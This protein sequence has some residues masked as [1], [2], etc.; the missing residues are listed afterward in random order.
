VGAL[1]DP[2]PR[3][4]LVAAWGVGR[5]GASSATD[6]LVRRLGDDDPLVAHVAVNSLVRLRAYDACANALDS[7]TPK[8]VPGA[9]RALQAMHE[10]RVVELLTQKLSSQQD[11]AVRAAV[12]RALCRLAYREADWDGG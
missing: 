6:A 3:L 5:L 1:D 12:Y 4:R 11:A 8:L 10:T 2:D 9:A 7:S